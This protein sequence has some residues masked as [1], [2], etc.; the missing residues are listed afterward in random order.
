MPAPNGNQYARG[1]KG[2][3]GGSQKYRPEYAERAAKLCQ[4]GFTDKNLAD[5]FGVSEST[6]NRWKLAYE[7]FMG[8][9][10]VGKEVAD[11]AVERATFL[12]II[13]FTKTIK[14]CGRSQRA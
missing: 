11:D 6:L 9:L 4:F 14:K 7:E 1:N 12:A 2:G 8:A 13:G 3:K 10:K 5:F